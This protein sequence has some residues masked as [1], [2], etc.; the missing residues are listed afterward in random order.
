MEVIFNSDNWVVDLNKAGQIIVSYF[1][2]GH[3]CGEIVLEI[4]IQ[5]DSVKVVRHD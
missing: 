5:K 4:K 1:S 3:Y 2:E